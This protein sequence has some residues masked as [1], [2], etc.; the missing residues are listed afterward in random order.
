MLRYMAHAI[1]LEFGE[2][3]RMVGSPN[4]RKETPKPNA[5]DWIASKIIK[6]TSCPAVG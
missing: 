3:L 5:N 2:T 4:N 1:S 6:K